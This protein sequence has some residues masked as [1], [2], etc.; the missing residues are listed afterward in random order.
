MALWVGRAIA[1]A[2]RGVNSKLRIGP[3]ADP[4]KTVK[5]LRAFLVASVSA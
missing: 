1:D 3:T 4:F 2:G 5:R